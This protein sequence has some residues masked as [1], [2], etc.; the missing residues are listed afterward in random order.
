MAFF[1]HWCSTWKYFALYSLNSIWISNNY[2]NWCFM[3]ILSLSTYTKFKLKLE[4]EPSRKYDIFKGYDSIFSK[5]VNCLL[6]NKPGFSV[7]FYPLRPRTWNLEYLMDHIRITYQLAPLNYC[8]D[9]NSP[10]AAPLLLA[11]LFHYSN[12]FRLDYEKNTKTIMFD[13]LFY[14]CHCFSWY[15]YKTTK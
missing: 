3:L 1:C 9:E 8:G 13:P 6:S 5:K 14:T 11:D 15:H 10:T 12:Q 2:Y 7:K 4:S